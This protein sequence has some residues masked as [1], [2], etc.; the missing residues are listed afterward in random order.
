MRGIM[1][2]KYPTM[3]IAAV[4][5]L[6]TLYSCTKGGNG[7]SVEIS[8]SDKSLIDLASTSYDDRQLSEII[9]FNGLLNELNAQYPI[10]CIRAN[11][12][13][14]RVSYLGKGC[15]AVVLFDSSGKKLLGNVYRTPLTRHDFDGLRTGQ[16]LEDV[17]KIDPDGDY[18]F[19][20]TG[21]NDIPKVSY[22][23]T[24]D[25]YLFT[26]EYNESNIIISTVE[27]MI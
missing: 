17:R 14:Y 19:L 18:L 24:K 9:G 22:H 26:I 25:G 11:N 16:S 1:K 27:E 7:M 3:I 6:F 20:F 10:E 4:L 12:D 8:P 5:M 21:R 13:I 15:V 23:Y 2:D